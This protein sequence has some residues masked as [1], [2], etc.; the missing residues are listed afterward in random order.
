MSHGMRNDMLY[1]ASHDTS[2]DMLQTLKFPQ[3]LE[4]EKSAP[5]LM[6]V[7]EMGEEC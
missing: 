1:D 2:Q 3:F 7:M 5:F 6:V 4:K